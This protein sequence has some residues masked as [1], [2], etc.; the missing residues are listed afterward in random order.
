MESVILK[1][2][3]RFRISGVF[4]KLWKKSLNKPRSSHVLRGTNLNGYIK[5]SF[6]VS[7]KVQEKS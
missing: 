6:N 3:F 1:I 7:A 5:T 2:H 4:K